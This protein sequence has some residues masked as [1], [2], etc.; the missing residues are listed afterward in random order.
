M[1][2]HLLLTN[3]I[4]DEA[5]RPAI[6]G[7]LKDDSLLWLDLADTGP[8][9]ITLLREV[10]NI[11]PLAVEDAQEFSQR[12]K[13]E[14]YEDF[15]YVVA[16]GSRPGPADGRGALFHRRALLRHRAPR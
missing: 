11:H 5:T 4:E 13:V 16:Y 9:T 14:D 7:A 3:C 15:V 12:P 6:E 2:G 1:P 8:D 10:F